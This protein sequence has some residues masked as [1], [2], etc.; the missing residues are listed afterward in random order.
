MGGGASSSGGGGGWVPQDR[1][2]ADRYVRRLWL[3]ACKSHDI[4]SDVVEAFVMGDFYRQIA[5]R[6]ADRRTAI[7]F[8]SDGIKGTGGKRGRVCAPSLAY[9]TIMRAAGG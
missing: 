7:E 1:L 3:R 4:P 9:R 8:V 2:T 5:L 6:F